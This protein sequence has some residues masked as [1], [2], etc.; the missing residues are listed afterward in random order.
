MEKRGRT[1]IWS[2]K[3]ATDLATF[4]LTRQARPSAPVARR[5]DHRRVPVFAAGDIEHLV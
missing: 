1:G 4:L 3:K 5:H 2:S